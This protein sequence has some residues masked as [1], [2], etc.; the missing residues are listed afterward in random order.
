MAEPLDFETTLAARLEARAAMA[1]RPFDAAAIASAAVATRPARRLAVRWP[2]VTMRWILLAG[3]AILAAL[4]G[5]LLA[6]GLLRATPEGMLAVV[7]SDGIYL[8][9]AD[10]SSP[11]FLYAGGGV[12]HPSWSA[13][14]RLLMIWDFFPEDSQTYGMR[15]TVLRTDG[16]VAWT[17]DGIAHEE[18]AWSHQG[19]RIAWHDETML[20]VTDVDTRATRPLA[21]A[22]YSP[23][24]PLAWSP[25]DTRI[26]ATDIRPGLGGNEPLIVRVDR[27]ALI[28]LTSP[29]DPMVVR[30]AWSGDGRSIAVVRVQECRS[31]DPTCSPLELA[32]LDATTGEVVGGPTPWQPA[33]APSWWSPDG[34]GLAGVDASGGVF[35]DRLPLADGGV[36]R[37][38]A[39][40]FVEWTPDGTGVLVMRPGSGSSPDAT[41]D[42]WRMDL[43]GSNAVL[44]ARG[45]FEAALQPTP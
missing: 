3:A 14:G 7:R 25:D 21:E 22:D 17:F 26:L 36:T 18:A 11:R 1:S 23:W 15:L 34:S 28:R 13:D 29:T 30:S 44:L 20:R 19:H 40:W 39:S 42:V 31:D 16:S 27:G 4:A 5:A 43:D 10:G 35:V 33:D 37:L 9:N 32:I 41:Q 8:A 2:T 12:G 24:S 6:G 38:D 45:A